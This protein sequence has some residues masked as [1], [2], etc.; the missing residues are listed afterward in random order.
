MSASR[1]LLLLHGALGAASQFDELVP[2]LCDRFDVHALNFAGHGG[3][4]PTEE[5]FS[6]ANFSAGLERWLDERGMEGADIFGYSMGG[7]VALHL[8]RRSP[9]H[10]GRIF[11]LATKFAWDEATSAKEAGMLNPIAIEEKVPRYAGQLKERHAP[12]DWKSVLSKTAEMMLAL[13]R[14]PELPI[15]DLAGVEHRVMIGVGDSDRMVSI[16]ESVAAYRRLPNGRFIVMPGTPHP[17][18]KVSSG[19]LVGEI[20][21]FFR[22]N[23]P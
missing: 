19:R 14:E 12:H 5:R 13:G 1:P 3:G 21:D 8:A 2:L 4:E 15:D 6:I 11:T 9:R 23:E 17:L 7:Y 20:D 16:E 10:V 18:E 22:P